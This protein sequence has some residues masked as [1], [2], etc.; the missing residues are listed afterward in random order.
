MLTMSMHPLEF[1]LRTLTPFPSN[2]AL[3]MPLFDMLC[4]LQADKD[5]LEARVH[6]LQQDLEVAKSQGTQSL[7]ASH[8][9][10]LCLFVTSY[11]VPAPRI[12]LGVAPGLC[13]SAPP[14]I[15]YYACST[16]LAKSTELLL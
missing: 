4:R 11:S 7:D 8:G 14:S 5:A 6:A 3:L 12:G 9:Y 13:K 2:L 16:L 10:L 15:I 1:I